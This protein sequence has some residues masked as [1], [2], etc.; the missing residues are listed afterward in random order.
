MRMVLYVCT[1]HGHNYHKWT[2][3][4]I[5]ATDYLVTYPRHSAKYYIYIISINFYQENL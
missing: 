4:A 1:S 5:K 3:I 2:I